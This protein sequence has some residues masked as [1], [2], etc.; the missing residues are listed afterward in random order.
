MNTVIFI[1]FQICGLYIEK[2][3]LIQEEDGSL[4]NIDSFFF[5]LNSLEQYLLTVKGKNGSLKV[6]L[7]FT[8]VVRGDDK[9]CSIEA[10][11]Q[12]KIQVISKLQEKISKVSH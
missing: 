6:S 4:S 5:V 3:E 10:N 7:Y 2:C 1:L 8:K 11:K 12:M 9:E